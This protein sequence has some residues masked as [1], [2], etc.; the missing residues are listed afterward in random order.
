[1]YFPN[2][3]EDNGDMTLKFGKFNLNYVSETPF[4]DF[5]IRIIECENLEVKSNFNV[6]TKKMIIFLIL[7]L[8][9]AKRN[10]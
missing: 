2:A 3:D 8:Q 4:E 5:S 7:I 10:T 1:M 6:H 9:K